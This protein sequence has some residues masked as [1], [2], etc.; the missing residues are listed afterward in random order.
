MGKMRHRG[1]GQLRVDRRGGVLAVLF[2]VASFGVALASPAW[3]AQGYELD[4]LKSSRAVGGVMKGIAVD[5]MSQDIY[6]AIVTTNFS[7][8]AP[9]Q[10]ERFNSN[11]SADGVF[12]P[13]GGFYTGV[14]V[15][16]VTHGFYGAQLELHTP[17]GNLGT[18]KLDRFSPT[19]TLLGSTPVAY[20]DSFPTLATDSAGNVFRPSINT[21]SVQVFDSSGVLQDE[22]TCSDCPGGTFDEPN[23]VALDSSD[24]LYVA[25][26]SPDR[27]VKL[28][29]SEG[30]Y[31]FASTLQSGRGAGS[32]AVDRA[33]DDILVGDMPNGKNFH[34]VAYNSSGT[35][36]DDF[37]AGLFPNETGGVGALYAYQVAV[38]TTTHKLY[39]GEFEKFFVFEKTTIAPPNP[40]GAPATS[41]GQLTARLNGS[42]NPNGHAVLDCKF[43]YIDEVDF[44]ASGFSSATIAPC[45]EKPAG[46]A[47]VPLGVDVTDLSPATLY[48]FRLTTASNA[49]STSSSSKMFETLPAVPPTVTTRTPQG[50]GQ[51]A[52]I[53][54]GEVN[55]HGGISSDC[56]FELGTSVSYGSNLPCAS[57][58][59]SVTTKVLE[60]KAISS[61]APG[62]KYHYRLVVTTNAGTNAG[63]DVEFL[64]SSPPPGPQP[65][66]P[67]PP[68]EPPGPDTG[69]EPPP[70]LRC[71]A[72][73]R[74]QRIDGKPRCVKVCKRGFQ[75]K[76]VRG[77]VRCVKRARHRRATLRRRDSRWPA[78]GHGGS[79]A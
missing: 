28:T 49:G 39:V 52:A 20:S 71:G 31:V 34:I 3:A 33:T 59:G 79:R 75:R 38:N 44:Q 54:E 48:R 50:V 67:S 73:F 7:V 24:D 70:G 8:G 10:I 51:A 29:L 30:S 62:T 41:I 63:G 1:V 58:P 25:D 5:Q 77:K 42:V 47:T 78:P 45:G 55:P 68:T 72:G 56:H 66:D 53:L 4:S 69:T 16:P 22:I 27:V 40:A 11:L 23:S 60:T 36:F 12:A 6:V 13:G 9:G 64:T 37:G 76:R 2:L 14:A 57:L 61:L 43:E 17:F 65:Q 15:D 19:G 35:Q 26:V 32:V 18:T 74:R 46:S 21:D